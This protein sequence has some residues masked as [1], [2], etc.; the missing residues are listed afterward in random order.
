MEFPEEKLQLITS[1][2]TTLCILF[3][4]FGIRYI[5]LNKSIYVDIVFSYPVVY[6]NKICFV[7]GAICQILT[8]LTKLLLYRLHH[9]HYNIKFVHYY[10]RG[11]FLFS[12][13]FEN[14]HHFHF[15]YLMPN[16]IR[17]NNFRN[18]QSYCTSLHNINKYTLKLQNTKQS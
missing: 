2:C 10:A 11:T 15:T 9:V 6:K 13:N 12:K 14:P 7:R 1:S 17:T 3:F 18:F 5:Y 4:D 8:F 16:T